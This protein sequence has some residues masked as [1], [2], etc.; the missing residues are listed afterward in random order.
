MSIEKIA[1]RLHELVT[2]GDSETAY[3]EL[4]AENTVAI[5]QKFPGFERVEGLDNIRKKGQTMVGAIASINSRSVSESKV[6]GD[7]HIALGI[8]LDATLKDGS[9]MAFSEV[10]LYEVQN[11]KIISEQ[12]FY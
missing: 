11:G 10:A 6:M 7:H 2:Q 5:E 12:F 3:R 9:R 4:F 8:S 1:A